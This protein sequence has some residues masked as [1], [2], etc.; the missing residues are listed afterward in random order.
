MNRTISLLMVFCQL[1]LLFN[2]NYAQNQEGITR[3]NIS[4]ITE[5]NNAFI[6]KTVYRSGQENWDLA[7]ADMDKDGYMDIISTVTITATTPAIV[8]GSTC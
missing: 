8:S 2:H 1:I 3:T 5:F 7:T 4:P 6:P